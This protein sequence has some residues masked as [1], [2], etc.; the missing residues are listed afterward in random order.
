MNSGRWW[1]LGGLGSLAIVLL[2][3]WSS[4]PPRSLPPQTPS[5]RASSAIPLPPISE[6][7]F[8][9]TRPDVAIVGSDACR[10][11]HAEHDSTFRHTSMGRSMSEV[12]LSREPP[13]GVFDHPLSKRRYEV[14]RQNEQLW[15]RELL[16]GGEP[17][18][19]VLSEFPVKYVVG[20]G[21]HSL[22]Y[23]VEVDGF[24]V[25]SPVTWY[26]SRKA[27]GMSPG[28]DHAEQ[29]GFERATGEG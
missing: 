3:I 12:D 7:P 4:R 6:S 5:G 11:C 17:D 1:L 16:L 21:H 22:T 28:Y 24:L 10:T 20:S 23:L 15:H 9:N 25:E 29:S 26:T 13:D 19:V 2:G 18:E 8:L 27:W 14:R